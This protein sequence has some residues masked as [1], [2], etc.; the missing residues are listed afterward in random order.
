M[1]YTGDKDTYCADRGCRKKV[2]AIRCP[3]CAGK[4]GSWTTCGRCGNSG[5]VCPNSTNEHHAKLG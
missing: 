5:Y 1:R 3:K 2:R 4:V